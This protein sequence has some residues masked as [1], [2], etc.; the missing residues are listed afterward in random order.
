MHVPSHRGRCRLKISLLCTLNYTNSLVNEDSFF[1]NFTSIAFQ[2][3]LIPHSTQTYY[4][5]RI[6]YLEANR[7]YCTLHGTNRQVILIIETLI[8][9]SNGE[10]LCIYINFGCIVSSDFPMRPCYQQNSSYYIHP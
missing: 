2:K 4:E 6:S 5:I 7:L 3:G 8:I 9:L 1:T 10:T